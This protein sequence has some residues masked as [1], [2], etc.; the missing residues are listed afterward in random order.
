LR[1]RRSL[2]GIG[3]SLLFPI[4]T[5]AVMAAVFH[6]LFH[7]PIRTFLPF[8]F[9]GLACWGY[10]TSA[11]LQGCQSYIQAESYIRQ[12]P[13]PL[14]VYPLRTALG[15]LIHFLIALGL[16]IVMTQVFQGPHA[17]AGM[18]W[19]LPSLVLFFV[20]GW[21]MAIL[22]GFLNTVFRDT[23]HILE[24]AFQILFYL[25]PIMYPISTLTQTR[26]GW[27]LAY[28][29]LAPFLELIRGPLLEGHH[30]PLRCLA[31][32]SAVSLLAAAAAVVSLR[33]QQRRVVFYL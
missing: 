15:A 1:Y 27:F 13:L 9:S 12:H 7:I 4:A 2:L 33:F 6:S 32:A 28:N 19:V 10:L 18:L 8:I 14:A 30:P 11:V 22:A 31:C 21:A 26:V 17:S 24:V 3:W 29:P 23:Q 5:A 16:V 20:F 25:T